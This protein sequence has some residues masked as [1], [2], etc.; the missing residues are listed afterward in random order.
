MSTAIASPSEL[1]SRAEAADYIRVKPQTLAVWHTT[2][3]Y[4]LPLV[5]VGSKVFYR[6]SDLDRW[7]AS[8]TVGADSQAE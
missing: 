1:L 5:K 2:R 6:K 7:L 4:H 8:R 3:R